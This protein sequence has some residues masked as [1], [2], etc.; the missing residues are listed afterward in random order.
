MAAHQ[1]VLTMVWKLEL[2][3]CLPENLQSY[4]S[5]LIE[6]LKESESKYWGK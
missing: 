4:H 6:L 3:C 1:G 5:S 2:K